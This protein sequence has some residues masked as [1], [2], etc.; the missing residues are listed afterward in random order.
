MILLLLYI[1][2]AILILINIKFLKVVGIFLIICYLPGF[3]LFSFGKKEKLNFEDLILA[4]PSSLGISTL[5]TIGLLYLGIQVEYIAF[6]I[7]IIT[8]LAILC[9][10]IGRYKK[11]PSLKIE[12]DHSELVYLSIALL[13]TLL[14]SIPIISE[15]VAISAHGFHH[16]IIITQILNGIFPPENPGLGGTPLSYYWGY[17]A[18]IAAFS[19]PI[20]FHPLRIISILNI[21]SLFFIFCIANRIAKFFDFSEGYRY[22]LPLALIGLM[23]SDAIIFFINK[24]FSGDLMGLSSIELKE[25]RPLDVLQNWVWGGG[26]PWYDRRLFF[27]NKFYNAN[28]MPLGIYLCLSY[29]LLLL[30]HLEKIHEY[31]YN[32]I[33]LINIC[34]IIIACSIIYPILAIIPLLHAPIWSGIILL[35]KIQDFKKRLVETLKI[36]APYSIAVIVVLPYFLS[37][38][39][40]SSGPSIKI[41]FW[42]QS[43]RNIIIF[44]LPY[45]VILWGIWITLKKLSLKKLLF[46]LT[47]AFLCFS[48]STFTQV[49]LWNSAKFTF[50]LSFFYA[51]FFIFAIS[52]LLYLLPN[53]WLK[54]I[55]TGGI[56]LFLLSTPILTESSYIISRWFKDNTYSFSG[57]HI[58]FSQDTQRNGAYMW[59]RNNTPPNSLIILTYIE[60]ANPFNRDKIGENITYEPAAIAERNL[61]VVKDDWYTLP[62]PEYKKRVSI[63]KKLFT[64]PADPEVRDF[65]ASLNR[66][67]Y[68]LVEDQLP[69]VYL[70]DEIF[71]NFP[72]NPEGFLL[73]Y[74]NER[75]RVYHIQM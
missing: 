25:M 21:T 60:T 31:G 50:I 6:I 16:S 7:Y 36:L 37:V 41:N 39:S 66:P 34:L 52:H 75:Q 30:M 51:I 23:R 43:I 4:F 32:K 65:F 9:Y 42:D 20:D 11:L 17:H 13:V 12:L 54:G 68:L 2:P 58:V 24:L 3:S 59:I 35:F 64:N 62:S 56:I 45:P 40:N 67:I 57:L 73:V 27:L 61:F 33:Y 47:G 72:E 29:F 38:S 71:K 63:R 19:F 10:I 70:K 18:L 8:A 28:A 1:L 5:L 22:L 46:L 26:A 48:L 14:L 53:R 69:P 44:W 49:A 55:I 15:R 74:R